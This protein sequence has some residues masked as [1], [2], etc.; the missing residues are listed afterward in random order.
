MA[1]H[2]GHREARRP[3]FPPGSDPRFRAVGQATAAQAAPDGAAQARPVGAGAHRRPSPALTPSA[4][5][6]DRH[7]VS[8][9]GTRIDLVRAGDLLL[10]VVQHPL[11]L[12]LPP[13]STP[14]R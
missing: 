13:W 8:H 12:P 2:G 4:S 7:V 5:V 9:V 10:L 3:D 11:P 1:P 6:F 14:Y